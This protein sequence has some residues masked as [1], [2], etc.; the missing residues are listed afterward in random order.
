MRPGRPLAFGQIQQTPFFGLPG[1]PVAVMV[2][3]LQFVEPAIRKLQGMDNWQPQVF[4]A[5]ATEKLRSRPGR[6]EYSRGIYSLDANGR[7]SVKTT[8]KQG[9]G[10]LR[11]MSEANCLI[12][13]VPEQ[14]NVEV[15]EMVRVIPLEGRI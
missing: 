10:I 8:G 12:E 9:S 2:T 11:S 1:N 14:P 13:I 7:L 6:T 5:I 4:N 3:F 15:G